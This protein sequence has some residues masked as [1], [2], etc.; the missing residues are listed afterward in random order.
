[1]CDGCLGFFA[2]ICIRIYALYK[3]A[4]H[5]LSLSHSHPLTHPCAGVSEGSELMPVS[6]KT[7]RAL[8]TQ[9]G[10]DG[11]ATPTFPSFLPLEV[12]DDSEFDCRT[13]QEWLELG[14]PY[15]CL[16]FPQK[17]S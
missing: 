16:L 12:F 7:S 17:L 10:E 15:F 5:N 6:E 11:K 2:V 8:L 1:M 14:Q 9:R 3:V 4:P 13:P